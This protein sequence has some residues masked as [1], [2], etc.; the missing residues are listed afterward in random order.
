VVQGTGVAGEPVFAAG[1]R[2]GAAT[3]HLIRAASV[4]HNPL[5]R[6]IAGLESA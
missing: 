3:R 1:L 4:I 6:P 2:D 5:H